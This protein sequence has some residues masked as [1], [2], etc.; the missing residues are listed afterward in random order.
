MHFLD[1][2]IDRGLRGLVDNQQRSTQ[3]SKPQEFQFVAFSSTVPALAALDVLALDG[4]RMYIERVREARGVGNMFSRKSKRVFE[5]TRGR[6]SITASSLRS[7]AWGH[8]ARWNPVRTRAGHL[9][10]VCCQ[11]RSSIHWYR[12][13]EVSSELQQGT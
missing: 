11:D 3:A 2:G 7:S 12:S 4:C 9:T 5:A 8:Q 13:F 1:Q 10:F 6:D